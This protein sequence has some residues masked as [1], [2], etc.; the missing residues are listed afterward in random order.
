L[1][2]YDLPKLEGCVIATGALA[3][4][5]QEIS[6][7]D[8]GVK[9][10]K[11]L[12][13]PVGSQLNI[14][15]NANLESF[16]IPYNSINA[17]SALTL[18]SNDKLS[19]IDVSQVTGIYGGLQ[20]ANNGALKDLDF[21]KLESIGG[22]VQLSGGFT[23]ISMPA[24]GS[25]N[26]ALRVEATGDI[27]SLC[28]NLGSKKLN[29]HYDCTA[30]SQKTT[31]AATT[32]GTQAAPTSASTGTG[33]GNQG[34]NGSAGGS[35]DLISKKQAAGIAVAAILSTFLVIALTIYILR[36]RSRRKVLEITPSNR[37]SSA[38]TLSTDSLSAPSASVFDVSTP[39][40]PM[41]LDSPAVALE[42]A[43]GRQWT[44]NELPAVVPVELEGSHGVSEID[45]GAVRHE[46]PG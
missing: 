38:K 26:G 28:S 9:S 37:N 39:N 8:T 13:W 18:S 42:L 12:T 14:S 4:E 3:G 31:G 45:K 19:T 5:I 15:G 6:I 23:N 27:S 33:S 11:W 21:G 10:L 16:S 22:F 34:D 17:G 40:S 2:W 25:I 43:G 24:L 30:N 46:L 20:V 7:I 36:R 32:G 41:E 29:G 35:S 1:K 44:K